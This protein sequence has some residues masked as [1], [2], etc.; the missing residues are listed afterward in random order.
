MGIIILENFFNKKNYGYIQ[1]KIKIIKS[2]KIKKDVKYIF[3]RLNKKLT[4]NYL[5]Q[6]PN[7][8]YII[9]QRKIGKVFIKKLP[10]INSSPNILDTLS[11][12]IFFRDLVDSLS[13]SK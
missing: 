11:L 12:I 1:K 13:A 7:L 10:N 6:F 5:N 2:K 4:S 3:C 8:K 9:N